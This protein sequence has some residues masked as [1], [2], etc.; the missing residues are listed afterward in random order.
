[1][2]PK[3]YI[4]TTV[5][6]YYTSHTS[7]DL[8]I[9]GHQQITQQ[10]W[11]NYLQNCEP[12]ISE[13]VHNEISHGDKEA[14][15][16]R[17]QAVHKFSFLTISKEVLNLAQLYYSELDLPEKARLDAVHL[18]LGVY[19]G[20]DFLV[21]WNFAHISGARPRQ[22]VERINYQKDIKTPIICTPEELME[23]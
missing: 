18:A 14:A 21:S 1:M 5:V 7:R 16:K 19:H 13:I 20:M 23:V 22:I 17:I 4:E 15:A 6:S 2:K 11:E 10:W 8:I 12:F 9:A 3:V